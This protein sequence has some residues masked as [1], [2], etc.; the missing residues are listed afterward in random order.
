MKFDSVKNAWTAEIDLATD[1]SRIDFF[2]NHRKT[3]R[4]GSE[5]H[6]SYLSSPYTRVALKTE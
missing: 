3:I 5:K 1:A 2:S 4:H 6:S